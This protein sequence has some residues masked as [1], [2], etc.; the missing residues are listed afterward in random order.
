MQ[1][2]QISFLAQAA[3]QGLGGAAVLRGLEAHPGK[4]APPG[5]NGWHL[6]FRGAGQVLPGLCH[7]GGDHGVYGHVG[8]QAAQQQ[9]LRG[10]FRKVA[11]DGG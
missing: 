2:R 7:E 11:G 1:A 8:R 4:A 5:L 3:Q 6:A 10:Q 9:G